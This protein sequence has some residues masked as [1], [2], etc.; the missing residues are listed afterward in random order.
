M[1]NRK[2][3]SLLTKIRKVLPA[4]AIIALLICVAEASACPTCKDGLAENDP[5][6]AAQAAGYFY[7]ILFMMAMPFLILGTLGSAAY[8]SIRRARAQ[9]LESA[10]VESPTLASAHSSS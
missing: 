5:A 4:I 9:K 1:I 3:N 7:S 2:S 10:V 8:L 6:S